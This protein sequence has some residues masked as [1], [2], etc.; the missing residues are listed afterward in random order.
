[1]DNNFEGPEMVM[2]T[3]FKHARS[4]TDVLGAK[5]LT[6]DPDAEAQK[7]MEERELALKKIAKDAVEIQTMMIALQ[8]LAAEE[9]ADDLAQID[10]TVV[11][12]NLLASTGLKHI[13]DAE[14]YQ[15]RGCQIS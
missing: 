15:Q 5:G 2:E 11:S 14:R 3:R 7:E 12:A 4:I 1:M 10:K 9:Q 6:Y 8:G 13:N